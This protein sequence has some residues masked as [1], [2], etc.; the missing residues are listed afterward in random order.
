[1]RRT[2]RRWLRP[3]PGSQRDPRVTTPAGA[4]V[5]PALNSGEGGSPSHTV[6]IGDGCSEV[7][8]VPYPAVVSG[9]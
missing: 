2:A 3:R 1:M 5:V 4:W 6:S 9:G 7:V 8:K